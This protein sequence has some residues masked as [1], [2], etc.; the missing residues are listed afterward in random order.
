MTTVSGTTAVGDGVL[1]RHESR[2]AVITI[3]RPNWRG[4]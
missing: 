4:R 3:N 2:V 1:A